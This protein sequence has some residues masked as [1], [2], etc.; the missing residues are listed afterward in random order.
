MFLNSSYTALF[1]IPVI[2]LLES[3]HKGLICTLNLCCAESSLFHYKGL[4]GEKETIRKS[5]INLMWL[6]TQPWLQTAFWQIWKATSSHATP[7][8]H[9]VALWRVYLTQTNALQGSKRAYS[10]RE[11]VGIV[12]SKRHMLKAQSANPCNSCPPQ[13]FMNP[14]KDDCV[15]DPVPLTQQCRRLI[16]RQE[17]WN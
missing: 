4:S 6:W 1:Y 5:N 12:C 17:N 2:I 8:S 13:K 10:M 7:A 14:L 11:W 16:T 3:I 9:F 15:S